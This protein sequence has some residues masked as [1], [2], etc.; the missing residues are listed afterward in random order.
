[1]IRRLT[2]FFLGTLLPCLAVA[3][4]PPAAPTAFTPS[5]PGIGTTPTYT[6]SSVASADEYDIWVSGPTETPILKRR[7]KAVDVCDGAVCSAQPGFLTNPGSHTWWVQARNGSGDSPMSAGQ[8][9]TVVNSASVS[10]GRHTSFALAATPFLWAWGANWSGELGLGSFSE[11]PVPSAVVDMAD[12][13]MITASDG[14]TTIL[15]SN[16]TVWTAGSNSNGQ[17]GHDGDGSASFEMVPGLTGV[18]QVASGAYHTLALKADGTVVAWGYGGTGAL[19]TGSFDTSVEPQVI[20]DLDSVVSVAAGAYHSLALKADGSVVAWGAN[21]LGQLGDGT[22]ESRALPAAVPGLPPIAHLASGSSAEHSFAVAVDGSI[23]A[24]GANDSGQLGIGSTNFTAT[25][26]MVVGLPGLAQISAGGA[27]TIALD[28][29]GSLYAWGANDSGQLATP[30]SAPVLSPLLLES[31][32]GIAAVSAGAYHSLALTTDGTVLSWGSNDSAQLGVG[33]GGGFSAFPVTLSGP[34][35][36]WRT[37]SPSITPAGGTFV[38]ELDATVASL[39]PDATIRYTI[40]GTEPT[41]ASPSISSGDTVHVDSSLVIRARAWSNAFEP[42]AVTTVAFTLETARPRANPPGGT[43]AGLVLVGLASE[44]PGTQVRYTTDG[45]EPTLAS[46]AYE[47][48]LALSATTTVKA[49]AFHPGWP[50]S[51]TETQQYVVG[52]PT[53]AVAAGQGFSLGLD[54]SGNVWAWGAGEQG[55]LGD[56]L[57]QTS[58][59]PARVESVSGAIGI[60]AGAAHALALLA[61]GTVVGWGN[62]S[63]G[64]LGTAAEPSGYQLSPT[65]LDG[66]TGMVAVAAG[67]SHSLALTADGLVY[68]WGGNAA[69]QL[70]DGTT[71]DR[72]LPAQVPSL[73]NIVAIAAGDNHSMAL[74]ADGRVYAW[75]D[76]S[77][78]Q[79][80]TG[81]YSLEVV[82]VEVLD[83]AVAISAGTRHSVSIR[84]NRSV[85]AW[86]RYLGGSPWPVGIEQCGEGGCQYEPFNDAEALADGGEHTLSIRADRHVW[87]WGSGQYGQLG[88]GMSWADAPT[89]VESLDGVVKIAAGATHSLAITATG[90]IWAWGRNTDGQIG[91]ATTEDRWTPTL[92]VPAGFAWPVSRPRFSPLPGSYSESLHVAISAQPGRAIRYTTDG[93]EVSD[94]SPLY[95]QPVTV[96]ASMQLSARAFDAEGRASSA[97]T[98]WYDLYFGTLDPPSATPSGG[99]AVTSTAVTLTAAPGARIYYQLLPGGGSWVPPTEYSSPIAVDATSTLHAWAEKDSWSSSSEIVESYAVHVATPLVDPPPGQYAATQLITLT[100]PTPGA[101]LRYTTDGREP[102]PSD[103]TLSS[104]T[105]LPVGT[106]QLKVKAWKTGLVTSP[107]AIAEYGRQG[108]PQA[109]DDGDGLTNGAEAALG[110]N[111][112]HADTNGDGVL[113]GLAV[114][115]GLSATNPDMDGDGVTNGVELAQGTN[116]FVADSDADGL[117]DSVDCFPSDPTRTACSLPD[118]LD[119]QPPSITITKPADARLVSQNP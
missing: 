34:G 24:W 12:V 82:P 111:P 18:V 62:N 69:G 48:L 42:S 23:Y 51:A 30:E 95:E 104:G 110:T 46:P 55:Q 72:A 26:T 1:M 66:L 102:T 57:G 108:D 60:A 35:L 103:M 99:P 85:W 67:Q 97:A 50:P 63:S 112:G 94:S 27:Y 78:G 91:D 77:W 38:R 70:G 89:L 41:E 61:D 36:L 16:G 6:W 100:S 33:Q 5:G 47:S 20:P 17:F 59:E 79:V 96:D 115:M 92:V 15:R 87:A 74:A 68:S 86:G 37:P 10:A 106:F 73:G 53:G 25:P 14:C 65:A 90:E 118:P 84:S 31:P 44:T 52:A 64:Q 75:G 2:L 11:A 93:S 109:D 76:D 39:A 8:S 29:E 54:P 40:D 7:Y 98:G 9:F 21:Y 45:S 58:S 117:G 3:D 105:T 114:A 101:T 19:G 43:Y 113:D 22:T 116:P 13:L 71:D 81:G 4:T 32:A 83:D 119:H 49:K 80:G 88:T 107:T 56:G 28:L